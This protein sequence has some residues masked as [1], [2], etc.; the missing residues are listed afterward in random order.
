MS[1][2]INADL[3]QGGDLDAYDT[4]KYSV[5]DDNSNCQSTV[6]IGDNPIL[7]TESGSDAGYQRAAGAGGMELL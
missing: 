2:Q 5:V 7:T 4:S 6:K 3:I 1:K